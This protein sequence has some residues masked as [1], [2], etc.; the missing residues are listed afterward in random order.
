VLLQQREAGAAGGGHR[1]HAAQRRAEHR[2]HR[3]DLVFHLDEEAV[4][5]G[6]LDR[7][8]LGDL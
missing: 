6:K 5:L 3:S 7:H 1:L 8:A 2:T 4:D